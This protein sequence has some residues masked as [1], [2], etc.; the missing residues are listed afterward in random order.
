MLHCGARRAVKLNDAFDR[1]APS[2]LGKP[3]K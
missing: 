1:S 3:A 2:L